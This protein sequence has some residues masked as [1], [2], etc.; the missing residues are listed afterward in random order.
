MY[1][2]TNYI[3]MTV[4]AKQKNFKLNDSNGIDEVNKDKKVILKTG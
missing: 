3:D 4:L 1:I 2:I